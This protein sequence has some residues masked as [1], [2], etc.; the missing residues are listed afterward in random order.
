MEPEAPAAQAEPVSAPVPAAPTPQPGAAKKVHVMQPIQGLKFV[1]A[2]AA[3]ALV[4]GSGLAIAQTRHSHATML[5]EFN[6]AADEI[7]FA[8][9]AEPEPAPTLAVIE[10]R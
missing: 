10:L 2:L 5:A 8:E 7:I 4:A 3:I 9:L 1:S 6:A